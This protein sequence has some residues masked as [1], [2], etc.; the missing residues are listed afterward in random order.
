MALLQDNVKCHGCLCT[1]GLDCLSCTYRPPTRSDCD[2]GYK[3]LVAS[4]QILNPSESSKGFSP[5]TNQICKELQWLC[6][7]FHISLVIFGE[8][9]RSRGTQQRKE[10]SPAG[11][12]GAATGPVWRPYRSARGST[13]GGGG[14]RGASP[15]ASASSSPSR[16][17]STWP[18]A[19]GE[20]GAWGG[21]NW[22][23]V[24]E[25]AS[26][27]PFSSCIQTGLCSCSSGSS[28][29]CEP[30]TRF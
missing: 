13:G 25:W 2:Q 29:P 23:A 1:G 11:I 27:S 5:E 16:L 30:G 6:Q 18:F 7:S 20:A 28:P 17:S 15:L 12:C 21:A 9:Q 10:R 3:L 4:A 19:E 22:T 8:F 14:G 24:G 26:A